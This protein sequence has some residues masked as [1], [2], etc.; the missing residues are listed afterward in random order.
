MRTCHGGR[1]ALARAGARIVLLLVGICAPALAQAAL[2][3][4][5]SSREAREQAEK[6]IPWRDL[7]ANQQRAVRHL[8]DNASLYRR[9]PTRVV[10]CDPE[11]FNF[12][13]QHPEVVTDV[14]KLMGIGVL[15]V[16]RTGP[17]KF[18]ARDSAGTTGTLTFLAQRYSP[19]ARNTL[20]LYGEGEFAGAPLPRSVKAKTLLLVRSGSTVE[21]NGRPYVTAVV[22][23]W[24][25]LDRSGVEL[26]A[27]TL[28]PLVSKAADHNFTET[29]KFVSTFSHT[30]ETNP[31]GMER[32][33]QKL[34]SADAPTKTE[35]VTVARATASR[36]EERDKARGEV[37]VAAA[38]E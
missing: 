33:S 27:K 10:D 4:A 9:L 29:M 23:T 36:S 21:T 26:V 38:I 32:L 20:L 22:D 37:R 28:Q 35:L 15:D 3:E 16:Q 12:L 19:E 18:T 14:W 11:L 6:M 25:L 1:R 24:V 2:P 30:A 5:T 7:E 31:D 13:T 17:G 8:V 34:P